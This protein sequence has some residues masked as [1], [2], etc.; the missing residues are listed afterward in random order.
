MASRDV[1]P[2]QQVQTAVGA[3]TSAAVPSADDMDAEDT[4]APVDPNGMETT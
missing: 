2:P 1:P 3:A 4:P